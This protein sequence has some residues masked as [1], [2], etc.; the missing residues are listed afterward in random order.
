VRVAIR[1]N[2]VPKFSGDIEF[3]AG[4]DCADKNSLNFENRCKKLTETQIKLADL[5]STEKVLFFSARQLMDPVTESCSPVEKVATIWLLVVNVDGAG[6]NKVAFESHKDF[7]IDTLP[8]TAASNLQARPGEDGI[9]IDWQVS[10]S[11]IKDVWY[12]QA[13]CQRTDNTALLPKPTDDPEFLPACETTP[14]VTGADAGPTGTPDAGAGAAD[15][16]LLA[17][18]APV[19][20]NPAFICASSQG[21]GSD[22]LV[23]IPPELKLTRHDNVKIT[24]VVADRHHNFTV[25]GPETSHLEPVHDFWEVFND[26]GGDVDGGYC[27]V[28]TAANGRYDHP[29]VLVLRDFR[30]HTLAKFG[31]GRAFIAW[32]YRSSPPWAEFI[33]QHPAARVTAQVVRWPVVVRAGAG[34]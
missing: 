17:E 11:N 19:G 27:F 2:R 33:R 22:M 18:A 14:P 31:A 6:T 3:Y 30:D 10:N 1:P 13:L 23:T 5:Q 12:Y 29:F 7:D 8:P 34:E 20:P 32:Y 26:A 25:L 28:A 21:S 15:A 9:Y 16:D 4:E 24:L